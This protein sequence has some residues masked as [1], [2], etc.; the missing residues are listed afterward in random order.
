MAVTLPHAAA[1]AR[2]GCLSR[3]HRR[4]ERG[5]VRARARRVPA[6]RGRTPQ[7]VT[8]DSNTA[9]ALGL[10]DGNADPSLTRNIPLLVP[11]PDYDRN[12]IA[13]YL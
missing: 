4:V 1:L 9:A 5:V 10:N 7:S 12:T 13:L 8:M 6:I 11:S 3:A 2:E